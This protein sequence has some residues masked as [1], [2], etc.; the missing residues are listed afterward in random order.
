MHKYTAKY[1]LSLFLPV[2]CLYH[3]SSKLCE[4]GKYVFI[5]IIKYQFIHFSH[6]ESNIIK[7]SLEVSKGY[8]SQ[9]SDNNWTFWGFLIFF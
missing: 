9:T 5:F 6:Y 4:E 2:V 7:I 1:K 3:F 8:K